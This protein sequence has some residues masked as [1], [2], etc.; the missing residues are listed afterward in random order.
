MDNLGIYRVAGA[1]LATYAAATVVCGVSPMA[2]RWL[3]QEAVRLGRPDLAPKIRYL[4]HPQLPNFAY[5]GDLKQRLVLSVAR[6]E[7]ED[8][9]QKNPSVLIKALQ[10]FLAKYPDWR[11]CIVGRG[12]ES[13]LSRLKIAKPATSRL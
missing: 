5:H 2:T 7:S 12:A 11:A 4:P 9:P 10:A 13:L 1:R 8:W 6:W 3:Q